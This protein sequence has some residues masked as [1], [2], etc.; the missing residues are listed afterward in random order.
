[1][2]WGYSGRRRSCDGEEGGEGELDAPRTK[3]GE[4]RARATLTVDVL[5]T[6]EAAEQRRSGRSDRDGRLRTG[7]RR[8]RDER[9]AVRRRRQRGGDFLTAGRNGAALLGRR[10]AV[11][12]ALLTCW[13]SAARGSHTATARCQAGPARRAASDRWDPLVSVFRIKNSPRMKIAQ[14]K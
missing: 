11:P 1:M 13:S 2:R 3:N 14:N 10:R 8:G 6:A 9:G 12:T 5:A 7:R 4:R